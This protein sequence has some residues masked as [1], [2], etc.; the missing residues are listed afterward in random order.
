VKCR[1]CGRETTTKYC[2]L[3][4]KAYE[5]IVQRFDVWKKALEISWKQYLNEVIKNPHTGTWAKEVAKDLL[6]EIK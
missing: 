4:E 3:H 6:C 5:R 2:E 1:I